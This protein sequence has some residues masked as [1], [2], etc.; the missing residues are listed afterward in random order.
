M[1][2]FN[3]DKTKDIEDLRFIRQM[4]IEAERE[5]ALNI[6]SDREYQYILSKAIATIELMEAK[7]GL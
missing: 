2:K 1:N 5:K 4:I 7:Y 3:Q 6:I